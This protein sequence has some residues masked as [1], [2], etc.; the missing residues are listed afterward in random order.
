MQFNMEAHSARLELRVMEL[1]DTTRAMVGVLK[2]MNEMIGNFN[3]MLNHYADS[4]SA[5]MLGM[6]SVINKL[7]LFPTPER[8]CRPNTP[9]SDGG[10]GS[11]AG[12]CCGAKDNDSPAAHN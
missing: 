5:L 4:F 2:T 12:Y 10:N 9:L 3:E 7:P 11:C 1:E 8:A 6:P